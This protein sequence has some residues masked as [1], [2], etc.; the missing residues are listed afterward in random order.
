MAQNNPFAPLAQDIE[1]HTSDVWHMQPP[2]LEENYSTKDIRWED[3]KYQWNLFQ[4]S[5]GLGRKSDDAKTAI[6]LTQAGTEA[7]RHIMSID[8]ERKMKLEEVIQALDDLFLPKKNVIIDRYKFNRTQQR[9][10]EPFEH[11]LKDLKEKVK[12]CEFNKFPG[13]ENDLLRDR[14]VCGINDD[15]LRR[16]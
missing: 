9:E 16:I 6:F 7:R 11:F 8:P 5:G 12:F 15:G 4:T 14:I 1:V 13:L 3:Y 10:G 2:K